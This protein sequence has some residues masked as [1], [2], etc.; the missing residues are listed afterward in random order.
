M[1]EED[2]TAHD[3][4]ANDP[5]LMVGEAVP[6]TLDPLALPMKM[7][8][9]AATQILVAKWIHDANAEGELTGIASLVEYFTGSSPNDGNGNA[10][11]VTKSA[12]PADANVPTLEETSSSAATVGAS[13]IAGTVG[14][15]VAGLNVV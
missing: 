13:V 7:T 1:G 9:D 10:E 3:R 4:A 12:S 14:V 2:V 6:D 15:I 11:N 5:A 8:L